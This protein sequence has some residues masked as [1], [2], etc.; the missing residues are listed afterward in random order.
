MIDINLYLPNGYLDMRSIIETGVPII[1]I[2]GARGTGKTF[3]ALD[4]MITREPRASLYMRR[5]DA[6]IQMIKKPKYSPFKAIQREKGYDV[7]IGQF[8]DGVAEAGHIIINDKGKQVIDG[9]PWISVTALSTFANLR[10]FDAEEIELCVYDEFIPQES[11]RVSYDDGQALKYSYE[12]IARN[13][14]I[15]GL[16]PLQLL[17]MA[18]SNNIGNNVFLQFRLVTP[19]IQMRKENAEYKYLEDRGILIIDIRNSPISQQKKDTVLYRALGDDDDYA[20]MAIGNEFVDADWTQA[21]SRDLRQYKPVLRY[22]ELCFYRHKSQRTYYVTAHVSGKPPSLPTNKV[23]AQKFK[24]FYS[25]LIDAYLME[26]M[27]FEQY[28]LELLLLKYLKLM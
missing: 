10:G 22:G 8:S 24:K 23:G 18:N 2:I 7:D 28:H 5:T 13:R 1:M 12:T 21:K 16:K 26:K 14:E 9:K 11:E 15:K 6:Q 17:C 25:N 3:G 20:R 19:Y 27:E 4:Y